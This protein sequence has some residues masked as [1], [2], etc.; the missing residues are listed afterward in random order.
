MQKKHLIPLLFLLSIVVGTSIYCAVK[1]SVTIPNDVSI[2]G[3]EIKLWRL[4]SDTEVTA[5]S[6]GDMDI[7][8]SKDS[9]VALGLPTATHKLAIKNTGDY[10]AY[11][12]WQI[13]PNTPLPTGLTLTGQHA[14]METEPY[15]QTWNENT[16]TFQVSAGQVSQ[17]RIRWT[18][19]VGA[20]TVAGDFTFNILLLVADSS[21]G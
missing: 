7:G 9:D 17:W 13:D 1:Y 5:I 8:S 10:V 11:V 18:L 16:F 14:N 20:E 6:W 12:G 2:K 4:D 3:Y 19:N 15:Q 21:T